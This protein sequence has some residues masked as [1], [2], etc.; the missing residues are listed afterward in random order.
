MKRSHGAFYRGAA[1]SIEMLAS[2]GFSLKY[3]SSTLLELCV[4]VK[5]VKMTLKNRNQTI[6]VIKF[7]SFSVLDF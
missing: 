2:S 3:Y 7:V 4:R 5:L 6:F 1:F